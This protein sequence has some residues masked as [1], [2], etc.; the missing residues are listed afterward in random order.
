MSM[1]WH[2]RAFVWGGLLTA[3][4][5]LSGCSSAIVDLPGTGTSAHAREP[6][7]YLPVHDLPPDRDEAVIPPDQRAKIEAELI[8]ARARQAQAQ[9]G[10]GATGQTSA[11]QT[12]AK[13]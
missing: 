7:P 11:A 12:G 5:A 2:K 10:Q 13:Q 3:A 8:A 1:D 4:L 6:D 9:A